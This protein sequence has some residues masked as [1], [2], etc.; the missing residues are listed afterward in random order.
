MPGVPLSMAISTYDHV[1]DLTD[2]RVRPEGIDLMPMELS[3][4]EIFFRMFS[5]VEWDV[6]EF[7]MA[8]YV[9]LVGTGT[10][11][12]RAIPVFPSRV[13]RQSAF[14]VATGGSIR[15]PEDLPGRR[16]GIPEWTQ[17]AGIYARAFLQHQ[18]GVR[19][20]DIHWVQAGVNQT[21][22]KEKVT[23]ILPDG[24]TIEQVHDRSLNELLLAGD[25]DGII[26]AREP[27]GFP[28]HNPRISRLWPDYRSVEEAYY[29]K[30]GVF[31]IMHVIVI[32]NETLDRHPWIAM[33]LFRAFDEAKTN[34]LRRL[35]SIV[36]SSVAVPWMHDAYHRAQQVFGNNFWPYGIEPNLQT[37]NAFLQY[38]GEQGVT[39]R[40][41]S[42]EE[43]F[44]REVSKVF[45]V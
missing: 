42:V 21:G 15:G 39:Q 17:T 1:R 43:L 34:S 27:A 33:N 16:I 31:P 24:V 12:F 14:Y 10:A 5:F 7:S 37:L 9:S 41:V 32:K 8:K 22:R 4:E 45:K 2:G 36:N 25:L 35:S 30:T 13:F 11:P 20:A 18:C 38:C 29:R 28:A 23:P 40:T 19:L 3:V 44:P 6:A 26:S